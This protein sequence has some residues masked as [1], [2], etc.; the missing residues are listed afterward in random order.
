LLID[1][2]SR[3]PVDVLP[4]RTS[5]A[6][7][8]WLD[9]HPGTEIVCRDRAGCYSEGATR[10]APSATQVADRWHLWSNLGDVVEDAVR[11]LRTQ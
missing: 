5:H 9:E 11:R 4:E 6:L 2:E 8:T 1:V 10:G 7:V 3:R